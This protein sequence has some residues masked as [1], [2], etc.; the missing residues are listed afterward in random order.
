MTPR[1]KKFV[2]LYLGNATEAARRAGYK[3]SDATLAQTG[4]QLLRKPEIRSAIDARTQASL[5][6]PIA[7]REQRQTFWTRV[8]ND[9]LE[10]M[11]ARLKASELLGKSQADFVERRQLEGSLTINV[12]NPYAQPAGKAPPAAAELLAD[13]DPPP[14]DR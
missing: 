10:K 8:M 4:A 7:T 14:E 9:E 3:G 6:G 13:V 11:E 1:Q 12:L 2:E 5:A